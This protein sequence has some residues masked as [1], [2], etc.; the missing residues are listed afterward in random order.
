[1]TIRVKKPI[2]VSKLQAAE[3][4]ILVSTPHP[5]KFNA[6]KFSGKLKNTFG[7]PVKYQS[8]LRNEWE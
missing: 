1:M 3:K 8:D 4:K 6:K 7:D 2:T 5:K